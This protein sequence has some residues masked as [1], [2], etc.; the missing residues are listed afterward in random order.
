[1]EFNEFRDT[2]HIPEDAGEYADDL[3]DILERIPVGW[4]RWI[5]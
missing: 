3:K 5:S 1:M 2:P 4:G